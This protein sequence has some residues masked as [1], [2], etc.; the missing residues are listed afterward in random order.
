MGLLNTFSNAYNA[1]SGAA[2]STYDTTRQM[3]RNFADD[4]MKFITHDGLGATGRAFKSTTNQA[5]KGINNGVNNFINDSVEINGNR[6]N[7]MPLIRV[8]QRKTPEQN[9]RNGDR[10]GTSVF[11]NHI[12]QQTFNGFPAQSSSACGG[13]INL[14]G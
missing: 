9:T 12:K 4:P 1:V 13:S 2:K 14:I 8:E 10:Q 7:D 11:R 5:I 6:A 3:G